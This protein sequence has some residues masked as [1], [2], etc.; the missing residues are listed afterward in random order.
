VLFGFG[1]TACS[2]AQLPL[3]WQQVERLGDRTAQPAFK[4]LA[5]VRYV[6]QVTDPGDAV[7]I[8]IP[9]SHRIAHDAGVVNVA[10][11]ASIES[12]PTRE[13]LDDALAEIRAAGATQ[14]FITTRFTSQEEFE[15]IVA[16]GFEPRGQRGETVLLVDRRA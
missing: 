4:Q 14:L 5:A 13:Q 10:P 3:P 9:L 2:L 7:A 16:A 1:L 6:E 12:M 15:A 11:Y 8:L